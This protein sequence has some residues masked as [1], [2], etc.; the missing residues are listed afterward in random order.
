MVDFSRRLGKS[1]TVKILDPV[2]VYDTLDRASDKGPLREVQ[3]AILAVWHEQRRADRDLILKLHTGQGK[4]LIGLL[5]LQSKLSETGEPTVYL[6]PNNFLI[7]QTCEQARQFGI[8]VCTTDGE[9]PFEFL[10]GK[11][12]LVTSVQKMFN[13]LTKFGLA[14]R[15]LPVHS[16]LM[17]DAHACIDAIRDAFLIRIEKNQAAYAELLSLFSED[18]ERQGSGTYA[19]ILNN[20]Q[21]AVLP[22]PYWAFEGKV[23]EV[24]QV[25]S[26]FS[27]NADIKFAWPVIKDIL[28]RCHCVFSGRAVEIAPYLHPLEQFGSYFKAKHR[29]F[30]SATIT[31]DAFLVKGLRLAP[32]TILNP[33]QCADEKW[34]GEKM[35][36]IP[37][38]IH[39]S[40]DRPYVVAGFGKPHEKMK[41]GIVTLV[42][43]TNG[44][45]DWKKYGSTVADR[46]SITAEVAKLRSGNFERTLVIVNRYDGIDL[47]DETCRILIVDSKPY[48]E[49]LADVYEESCRSESDVSAIRVARTIEQGLGRS[50]RGEKDYCVIILIGPDLIRAVR[51]KELRKHLSCQTAAQIDLGLEI[52]EMSREEIENGTE[53]GKV[54]S[55]VI[56]QCLTRDEGWKQFYK[57]RM[58]AV[59]FTTR[60]SGVLGMLASELNAEQ[61]YSTGQIDPA[62]NGIQK[63][64]D[65][66]GVQELDRGWYMQVMARYLNARSK[67]KAN[68]MQLA[69]HKKN[70]YLLKPSSGM[71]IR[72]IENINQKRVA[73][74]IEWIGQFE[75][76]E[77]LAVTV[78]SILDRVSFGVK[79]ETFERSLNELARALGF[80]NQRP[81][82]EWGEGPDNLWRIRSGQF[83]LFECKSEADIQRSEIAKRE[84]EQMNRSVAWFK[85]YYEGS[86]VVHIMIIPTHVLSTSASFLENVHVMDDKLLKLMKGNIKTFFGEFLQYDLRG[87]SEEKVQQLLATHQLTEDDL[88]SKYVRPVVDKRRSSS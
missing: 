84:A 82:K 19:D 57:A 69:A 50:V 6:C 43:S 56:N 47:P 70:T 34:S 39:E 46:N 11:A 41:S 87:L 59:D 77:E 52:V 79:A 88:S 13:G 63:L 28:S 22:V 83:L 54:F 37:S 85:K 86:A 75:T 23:S 15:S 78:V 1:A 40:M 24:A 29:V 5:I 25:L 32:E 48:S 8:H 2:A 45:A 74:I 38:L 62:V 73:G 58:D 53:P 55:K 51:T 80:E 66:A 72:K 7:Q 49:C 30:M 71:Q 9:L 76:Y 14:Q 65:E 36:L 27:K 3:K 60:E 44:S 33:L 18:L 16:V 68:D 42:P 61:L 21:E 20:I 26:K 4:T 64:I 12:I 67:S 31:D 10:D 17:D 35:I 81:D